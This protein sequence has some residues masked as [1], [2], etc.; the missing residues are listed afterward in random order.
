MRN[1]SVLGINASFD[2]KFR[3]VHHAELPSGLVLLREPAHPEERRLLRAWPW[4]PRTLPEVRAEGDGGG[5]AQPHG[6]LKSGG[7]GQCTFFTL[8]DR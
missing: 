1:P 8:G 5:R 4:M 6:R 7:R 3:P 2:P